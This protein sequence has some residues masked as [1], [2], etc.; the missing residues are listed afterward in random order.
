MSATHCFQECTIQECYN[1][2]VRLTEMLYHWNK[3]LTD[4]QKQLV[5][6]ISKEQCGALLS[7]GKNVLHKFLSFDYLAVQFH[8]KLISSQSLNHS[9]ILYKRFSLVMSLM[10]SICAVL[11]PT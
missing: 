10:V 7:L 5:T 11:F 6:A 4:M 2:I 3:I 9:F 1:R 8:E